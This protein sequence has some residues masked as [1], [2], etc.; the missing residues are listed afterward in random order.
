MA[1]S[2]LKYDLKHDLKHDSKGE[3]EKEGEEGGNKYEK[4]YNNLGKIKSHH[5][6]TNNLKQNQY[7]FIQTIKNMVNGKDGMKIPK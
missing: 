5:T 2:D 4:K 3:E 6:F 1:E 7:K